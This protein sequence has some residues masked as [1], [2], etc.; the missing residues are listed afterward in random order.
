MLAQ[1]PDGADA[2]VSNPFSRKL[3]IEA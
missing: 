1:S 2:H 3:T